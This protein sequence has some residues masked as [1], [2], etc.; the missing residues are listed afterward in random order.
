MF[1]KG[2]HKRIKIVLLVVIFVF[3]VIIG[4]VFYIEVI[5]YGK[6][7]SLAS[8]LWSR[9]LPIEADRGKIYTV[10]GEIVAGNLTTTS[11]VFVPNQVK[12][13]D[14]VATKISEI[15]GVEKEKIEEHL[16]KKSMME[17]VHPEG[18][19]LA[20]EIADQIEALRFEGVYLL[21]E[22]KRYYPH[23]EMLS[24]VLGYVGIDNQGLS[25]L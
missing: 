13:K 25:G 1:S 21:K 10:D 23:D 19:R 18:R 24:H 9:N 8:S 22:S 6:L 16:Y 14:L 5:D 11:L 2:I 12:D 3:V 4:K 20:Y 7:N 15:L 17:R